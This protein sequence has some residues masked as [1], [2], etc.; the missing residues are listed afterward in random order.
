VRRSKGTKFGVRKSSG[1]KSRKLVLVAWTLRV[2]IATKMPKPAYPT[3]NRAA[4]TT[5]AM[6]RGRRAG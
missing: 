5:S 6:A 2:R 4:S 3:P 1:K